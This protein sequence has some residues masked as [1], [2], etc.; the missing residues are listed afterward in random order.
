M[1]SVLS[2]LFLFLAYPAQSYATKVWAYNESG[3]EMRLP[4]PAN[5]RL[6]TIC[7]ALCCTLALGIL[8]PVR[9]GLRGPG[10]YSGVVVFDR[11]DTCFLLSGPY[12]IYISES[13][14]AALR[15]FKGNAV[16]VDASEVFQPRN[17]GDAVIQK[18]E[19]LG[20]APDTHHWAAVDGLEWTVSADFQAGHLPAFV[21]EVRNAS[22]ETVDVRSDAIGPVLLGPNPETP[23]GSPSDGKSRAWITRANLLHDTYDWWQ[24]QTAET[25]KS[26]AS[27]A[28]DASSR[29]PEHFPLLPHQS[30]F[31][32]VILQAPPGEYQFMVGYG[33][34][35][36][37]EKSIA[38][39]AISF[40]LDED[41]TATV[42][43]SERADATRSGECDSSQTNLMFWRT[44]PCHACA[45]CK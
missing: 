25:K 44:T 15:P 28:I 32:R 41:N 13:V 6:R 35:V 30:R 8:F 23:W 14:K 12:I 42:L 17:P 19:I 33:G 38:S 18:Y 11:W 34:G 37:E 36:H 45:R 16:Q 7:A 1:T 39:N 2:F 10:K 43:V 31:I 3:S 20:P 9:A 21:I 29:P 27:Y 4:L 40:A 22:G 24:A 26:F 5:L